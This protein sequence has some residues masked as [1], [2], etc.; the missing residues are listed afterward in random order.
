ML[1]DC[2]LLRN[3]LM[4]L[5]FSC[6][7][8]AAQAQSSLNSELT[9]YLA[10]YELP[11]LAA[12]V[13]RDGKIIAAGAVG[14]RRAGTKILVT[15]NDRFHL[16]SDTK[17]MTALLA[18]MLVEQGKLRWDSTVAEVFPELREM[19]DA[20]FLRVTLEQLLSHTSGIPSDNQAIF[21]LWAKSVFEDGNLDEQRYWVMKEWGRSKQPLESASG[22]RF[23]YA[24]MGYL[25]AGAMIERATGRTWDELMTERIFIPLDLKTAGLGQQMSMGKIDAPLSHEILNG[26]IKAFL[27]GP[28]ADGPPVIGP[29]GIAHM[30]VLD[31]ARWAG[32]NAGEGRRGP[33]LVSPETMRKLHTPVV[34][35]PTIKDAAPGTPSHGKYGLG[36]GQLDVEWAPVPLLYHG[37]SNGKNLAHIWIEPGRDF[38]MVVVTNIS[39]KR[40]N[41]AFFALAPELYKKFSGLRK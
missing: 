14:T 25:T 17:A 27:G 18:A 8:G 30:S 39:N 11:A 26:K 41:E 33:R 16:G 1:R 36:W 4:V 21:D 34:G 23:A 35:M 6:V 12:A 5:A 22:S 19:A 9:P 10:R 31:F 24:N 28:D 2:L 32:W 38:A 13:V 7:A 40:A 15:L 3:T 29:A 20:D 37:G